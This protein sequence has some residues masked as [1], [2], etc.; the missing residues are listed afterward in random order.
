[1]VHGIFKLFY[2]QE[3][4]EKNMLFFQEGHFMSDYFSFLTGTPSIRPIK[5]LEASQLVVI[6][7][8][9]LHKLYQESRSWET[10]GRQVAEQA[11]IYAVQRGN[12]LIHDPAE[13]RFVTFL[14]EYPRL[15]NRIPQYEIASYLNISP[16]TL[17][18]LRKKYAQHELVTN[19]PIHPKVD[20]WFS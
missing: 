3:G 2:R 1:V 14:E 18:R 9:N 8:E 4:K 11:Y 19:P 7:K 17:S 16:E 12:R 15:L 5:A 6:S 13:V 10:F 20:S